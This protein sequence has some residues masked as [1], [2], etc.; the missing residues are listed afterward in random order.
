MA[1][2]ESHGAIAAHP[3]TKRLARYLGTTKAAAIGHLH[4]LWWWAL[5]YALDGHLGQFEHEELADAAE[6]EGEPEALISA[7]TR[8][9]FIEEG[10]Y[11]LELHDW[12]DFTHRWQGYKSG[13]A[14]RQKRYREKRK[15]ELD[16]L[17][18]GDVTSDVTPPDEP[19]PATPAKITSLDAARTKELGES[20]DA[21]WA[22]YPRKAGKGAASKAWFT[23][24]P[25]AELRATIMAAIDQHKMSRDW[26]KEDGAYIPHPT[27]WLNQKRWEDVLEAGRPNNPNRV[28]GGDGRLAL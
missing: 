3:K 16:A 24:K 17:R 21:F 14:E 6:W 8:S 5:E 4:L 22:A 7:L 20:F 11:G 1:W 23:L 12:H 25:S 13:N 27:T 9:G 18:N 2:I 28:Y 10:E 15:A 19:K 26:L